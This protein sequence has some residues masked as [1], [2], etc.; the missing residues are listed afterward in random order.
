MNNKQEWDIEEK[1]MVKFH[2]QAYLLKTG[3]MA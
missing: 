1:C 3:N 2:P